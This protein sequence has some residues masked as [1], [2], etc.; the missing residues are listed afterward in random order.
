MAADGKIKF[1]SVEYR[2]VRYH[3]NTLIRF[4]HDLS[5]PQL[6]AVGL[7]GYNPESEVSDTQKI[8]DKV[9]D[10]E[11]R[12]RLK[13][14]WDYAI[15]QVSIMV[16]LRSPLLMGITMIV[17]PLIILEYIISQKIMNLFFISVAKVVQREFQYEIISNEKT[18]TVV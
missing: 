15:K 1:S 14:D 4:A 17:L 3:Y 12:E 9:K 2:A 6:V 16:W 18:M 13:R 5:W 7:S 10:P 11:L 8:C